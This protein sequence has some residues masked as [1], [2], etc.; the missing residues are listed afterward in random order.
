M[1]FNTLLTTLIVF[2]GVAVGITLTQA[3]QE[4]K[5]Q[6]LTAD[7][8]CL[9]TNPGACCSGTCCCG[10]T[11]GPFSCSDTPC[12]LQQEEDLAPGIKMEREDGAMEVRSEDIAIEFASA[13]CATSIGAPAWIERDLCRGPEVG[14]MPNLG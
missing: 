1:R 7:E 11:D 13:A 8:N 12:T 2:A 14:S 9:L 5:R 6:C 4:D 10:V 3:V